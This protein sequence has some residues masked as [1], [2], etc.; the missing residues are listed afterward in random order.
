MGNTPERSRENCK[1]RT[2]CALSLGNT[3]NLLG[4]MSPIDVT[5]ITPRPTSKGENFRE[6]ETAN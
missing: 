4:H 5:D 6:E 3:A 2:R 1:D